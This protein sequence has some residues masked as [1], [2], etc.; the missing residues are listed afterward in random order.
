MTKNSKFKREVRARSE[1]TGESYTAARRHLVRS[2]AAERDVPSKPLRIGVAQMTVH[3]DPRDPDLLRSAGSELRRLMGVAKDKGARLVQFPEGATCF[4]H[5][6]VLSSTGPET[7]GAADWS[8]FRWDVLREEL[9]Q[10]RAL[11]R[12]LGLWTVFGSVHQLTPPNRPHN[13]LYVVSDRGNLATRYDERMLSKT[14]VSFMYAPGTSAATFEIDGYRFG[15]ALGMESHFPEI[16]IE[17][18]SLGVD[19]VLF[20]TTGGFLTD[21]PMFAAGTCG[22]AATNNYWITFSV[23][24]AH[25]TGA[26]AGIV[27]PNGTWAAQCPADGSAA[28]TAFDI[29]VDRSD[30]SRPWRQLARAGVYTEHRVESD[31]RSDDRSSF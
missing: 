23:P 14:K 21:A 9:E 3:G 18:E 24:A 19:C 6:Q 27:A 17:Y 28:V 1:K 26:P 20:S 31:R 15:C 2:E 13:S 25:S 8:R 10:T 16:F 11:A 4:P 22:N 5:K 29:T 12:E 30:Y 7:I